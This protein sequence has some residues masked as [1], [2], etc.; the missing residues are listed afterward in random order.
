M[1]GRGKASLE[2]GDPDDLPPK[3]LI[4]SGSVLSKGAK[5]P[6]APL[7]SSW[8]LQLTDFRG[9]TLWCGWVK[10]A[11]ERV[12]R[13]YSA[14]TASHVPA[15]AQLEYR[16][17]PGLR[18]YLKVSVVPRQSV[19]QTHRYP[20]DTTLNLPVVPPTPLQKK[21]ARQESGGPGQGSRR[22]HLMRNYKQTGHDSQ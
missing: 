7:S 3:S 15:Q 8:G 1:R 5:V 16:L 2:P 10:A 18:R 6:A 14:V 20:E 9:R 19:Q 22:A 11:A 13:P 17:C 4:P 21:E 12:S